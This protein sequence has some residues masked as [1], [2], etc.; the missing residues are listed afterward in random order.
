MGEPQLPAPSSTTDVYLARVLD[1]LQG[2]RAD[3]AVAAI[4]SGTVPP[5]A[6]AKA[7]KATKGMKAGGKRRR[8]VTGQ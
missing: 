4:Q 5:P 7:T 8:E 2:L 1:E 6:P 3:L